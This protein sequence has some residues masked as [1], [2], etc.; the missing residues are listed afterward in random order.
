[1]T[2]RRSHRSK[3]QTKQ[4][5]NGDVQH[6]EQER[7][8][9]SREVNEDVE[10]RD[11]DKQERESEKQPRK[12]DEK[13]V[14][15]SEKDVIVQQFREWRVYEAASVQVPKAVTTWSM[16]WFPDVTIDARA[17][18]MVWVIEAERKRSISSVNLGTEDE[19][20]QMSKCE[21]DCM[22]LVQGR[23]RRQV[24]I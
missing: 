12:L 22:S 19:E 10:E 3:K 20:R 8:A 7:H 13:V 11:K 14:T 21:E 23:E 15:E 9:Q 4:K 6:R 5:K 17:A 16:Q 1:M 24:E 2:R 18:P